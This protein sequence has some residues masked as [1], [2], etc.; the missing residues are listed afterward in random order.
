M[1][2]LNLINNYSFIALR[3]YDLP[4]LLICLLLIIILGYKFKVPTNYQLLLVLHCFLPFV[5]NDVLF[6][7][8]YMGDQLRYW[9][10]VNA[11]RNGELGFVEALFSGQNVLQAS[12]FLAAIPFPAP[13]SYISLG[14]YNTALYII[15]FFILYFKNIFTKFTVWFYLLFPSAALYTALSL[16]ETLIFFFMILTIVFARESKI[17]RSI[18][19]II[20][21]YVI[22]FQNFFILGPI[23]LMYFIFS[24]AQ[25]GMGLTKAL[26]ISIISLTGLILSAPIAIPLVNKYR[27]AMYLEDGG[28]IADVTLIAGIGDFVI[29]GITSGLYF[30]SKPFIWE[31]RGLLPFI[32]SFENLFILS[33]LFLITRNAWR[34]SPD[35]LAFWL[36]FMILS[37][38][39]YGLVVFNYGTAVRYRYPFVMIYVLFVCADC[40]I[41][42]LLPNRRFLFK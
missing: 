5:L 34:K 41:Q 21:I 18:L 37:M 36:L 29:Q 13:F 38:S 32:Q 4:A 17:F 23:V 33:I 2:D 7:V 25:K 9:Q 22:K 15:L 14:F 28:D 39:V 1:L 24:V 20:P 42:Q 40:N 35:K 11:I 30:L 16:R 19:C 8:H 10:G 27:A 12:A 6:S 26:I 31:A 3:L